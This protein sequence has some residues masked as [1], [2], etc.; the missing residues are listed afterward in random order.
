[1]VMVNDWAFDEKT[2]T[3]TKDKIIVTRRANTL[4]AYNETERSC[5]FLSKKV[6][7]SPRE[8]IEFLDR[9]GIFSLINRTPEF[10]LANG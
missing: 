9:V 1:M 3:Y 6:V 5:V 4:T 2:K 10:E 7:E 8:L